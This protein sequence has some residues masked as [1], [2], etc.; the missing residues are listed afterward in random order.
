MDL[1]KKIYEAID[2]GLSNALNEKVKIIF[3]YSGIG[4]S[5]FIKNHPELKIL[6]YDDPK[7][8][9][10]GNVAGFIENNIDKF[11]MIF[12]WTGDHELMEELLKKDMKYIIVMPA[13]ERLDEFKKMW[14]KRDID[15]GI[16]KEKAIQFMKKREAQWIEEHKWLTDFSKKYNVELKILKKGEYLKNII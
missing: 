14:I 10:D 5:Y 1:Y 6:D 7:F 3:G 16:S 8:D 2:K 9:K 4:K 12:L 11:D 15:N 13:N